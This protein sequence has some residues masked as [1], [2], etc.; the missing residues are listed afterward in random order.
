MKAVADKPQTHRV[1]RIEFE[2]VAD[3][4]TP[5]V[6]ERW[7]RRSEAIAA[8]LLAEWER[9]QRRRAAERN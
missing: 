9:E 7:S 6:E 5:E 3:D 8:W 1:G 4:R 2:I